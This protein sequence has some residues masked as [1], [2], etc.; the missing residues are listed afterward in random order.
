MQEIT[1]QSSKTLT[2][3]EYT[4]PILATAEENTSVDQILETMKGEGIRHIPVTSA[5]GRPVGII[6]ERD[7][8]VFS[9]NP[10]WASKIEAADI[11]TETPFS[12][13]SGTALEEVVFEM[14]KRKV[15][16]ALVVDGNSELQGIFTST[17]ALNALVEV[18][19]GL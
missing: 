10:A 17:D 9:L 12:V 4:T 1:T 11:M 13:T 3:D 8:K 19:R 5:E 14:S 18:L 6:S 15:G 2:V 16:S 7:L